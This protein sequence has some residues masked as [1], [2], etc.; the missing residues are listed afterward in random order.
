MSNFNS[1][2]FSSV[3][4]TPFMR[5]VIIF[6]IVLGAQLAGAQSFRG[7]IIDGDTQAPIE[8]VHIQVVNS[9]LGT[10]SD[11]DGKFE[12]T[13]FPK[14]MRTI[15][16]SAVGYTTVESTIN[17]EDQELVV[18]LESSAMLLNNA[19]TITAQRNELLSFDVS[20]SVTTLTSDELKK[21]SS[22][23]TPEALMNESGIWKSNFP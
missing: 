5:S 13:N 23:S 15:R 2:L 17:E 21:K 3:L 16:I 6:F 7:I 19:V 12:I 8:G 11:K 9:S 14:G 4:I 20:Q 22:R 10:A 18:A 1:R